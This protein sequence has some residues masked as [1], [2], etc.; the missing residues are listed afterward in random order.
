VAHLEDKFRV[1]PLTVFPLIVQFVS[2]GPSGNVEP[3]ATIPPPPQAAE[4]PLT[5][6]F[7]TIL[8]ASRA[9]FRRPNNNASA[10]TMINSCDMRA[11]SS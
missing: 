11:T 9:P 10:M 3:K 4:F 5:V 1:E 6:Q 7:A 2:V 8:L